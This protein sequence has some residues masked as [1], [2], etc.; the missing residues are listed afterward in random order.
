MKARYEEV[1]STQRGFFAYRRTSSEFA[2][3]WHYHPEYELTLI[4]KGSGQRIIGDS[5]A[6]YGPGDLVFLGPNLPH[7]W[8]SSAPSSPPAEMH[9]AIIIQFREAHLGHDL[10]ELREMRPL[11]Q[12]FSRSQ[13]GLAFSTPEATRK[14]IPQMT[15]LLKLTGARRTLALL[16]LLLDLAAEESAS[17]LSSSN[18]RPL[19]RVEEEQKMNAICLFLSRNSRSPIHYD[20]LARQVAMDRASLCRFFKRASGRTM[21]EYV[22][23]VRLSEAMKLLSETDMSLLDIAEHVGF[24]NYANFCRQF[25]KSKGT[26]ARAIRQQF[27]PKPA[28][29]A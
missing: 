1:P 19:C 11:A 5:I 21:S 4:E 25:K 3:S 8:R 6:D 10:L 18:V 26:S 27:R 9:S 23:E 12:L 29:L 7:T 17:V 14:A 20:K 24:H 28:L 22:N 2:F 15:A 13:G 16:S